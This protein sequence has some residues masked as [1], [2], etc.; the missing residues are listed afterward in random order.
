MNENHARLWGSRE[1]AEYLQRDV[2][3]PLLADFDL[4]A[5]D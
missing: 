3:A 2:I 5:R 4:G 1:W